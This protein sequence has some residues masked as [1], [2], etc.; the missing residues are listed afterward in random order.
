MGTTEYD[1]LGD[2]LMDE[3]GGLRSIISLEAFVVVLRIILQK[4][5]GIFF[6]FRGINMI[7]YLL[8]GAKGERM[9]C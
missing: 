8:H 3:P 9:T 6:I 2:F 1:G 4:I 5:L 7:R